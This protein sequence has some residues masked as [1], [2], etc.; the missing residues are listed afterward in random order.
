MALLEFF[1][2]PELGIN[3]GTD[4]HSFLEEYGDIFPW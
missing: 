4:Q 2:N 1:V 3:M